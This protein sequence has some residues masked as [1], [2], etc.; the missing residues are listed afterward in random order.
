MFNGTSSAGRT[1]SVGAGFLDLRH[2]LVLIPKQSLRNMTPIVKPAIAI[3]IIAKQI[4]MKENVLK[5]KLFFFCN[6]VLTY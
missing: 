6:R 4:I 3:T 1:W 2:N 5:N